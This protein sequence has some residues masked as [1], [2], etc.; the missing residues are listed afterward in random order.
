VEEAKQGL[1]STQKKTE[2]KE[3]ENLSK[4]KKKGDVL[5]LARTNIREKNVQGDRGGITWTGI[6]DGWGDGKS[7]GKKRAALNGS[8]KT[9][10]PVETDV[11]E[12][13]GNRS[14]G[15]AEEN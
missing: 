8:K 10:Q 6:M 11:S 4:E 7:F 2:G 1:A 15:Q 14:W 13:R 12:E 3:R 5:S 9:G